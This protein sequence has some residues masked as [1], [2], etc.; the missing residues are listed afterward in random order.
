[1]TNSIMMMTSFIDRVE[2]IVGKKEKMLVSSIFYNVFRVFKS[3]DYVVELT[4]A[5]EIHIN[6]VLFVQFTLYHSESF[7]VP[8]ATGTTK[9]W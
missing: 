5:D 9:L 4:I 3:Q 1:M 2:N 8:P 6:S 7:L